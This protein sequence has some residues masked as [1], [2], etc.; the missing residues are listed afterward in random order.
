MLDVFTL[1]VFL[2]TY[3]IVFSLQKGQVLFFFK[4][5]H[6][7][8]LN[9][10]VW[11]KTVSPHLWL[12]DNSCYQTT[13]SRT[14]TKYVKNTAIKKSDSECLID[15]MFSLWF[16]VKTL[17]NYFAFSQTV[18]FSLCTVQPFWQPL[19]SQ[20]ISW[21]Q[22]IHST[23]N[24]VDHCLIFYPVHPSK[25]KVEPFAS[26]L[27]KTIFLK[28]KTLLGQLN[29]SLTSKLSS[30]CSGAQG[31]CRCGERGSRRVIGGQ[32]TEVGVSPCMSL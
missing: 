19:S 30:W 7:D 10:W 31:P 8:D 5:T 23:I 18:Y 20:P 14:R 17:L 13:Q 12:S 26:Q 24:I 3:L 29:S 6:F 21:C 22:L 32:A 1:I 9:R 27:P 28:K 11:R 15:V 2:P 4:C 16:T 25:E